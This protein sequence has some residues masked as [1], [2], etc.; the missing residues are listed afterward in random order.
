MLLFGGF[1]AYPALEGPPWRRFASQ[2]EWFRSRTN[3]FRINTY[4]MPASVDSKPLTQNLS[5]LDAT[6]TENIGGAVM[7]N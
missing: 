5:P 7:V 3:P 6:L 4:G 1:R 2:G